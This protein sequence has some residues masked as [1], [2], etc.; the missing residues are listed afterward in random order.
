MLKPHLVLAKRKSYGFFAVERASLKRLL[1]E[2]MIFLFSVFLFIQILVYDPLYALFLL[3]IT[4]L[5]LTFF[6]KKKKLLVFPLNISWGRE[7]E[8]RRVKEHAVKLKIKK[9]EAREGVKILGRHEESQEMMDLAIKFIASKKKTKTGKRKIKGSSLVIDYRIP[10]SRFFP[11]ALSATI[12]R[13][14]VTGSFPRIT[15]QDLREKIFGGKGRLSLII[16]LDTSASMSFSIGEILSSFEAIKREAVRYRD[17]VSL[18]ICKG[19]KAHILQHPTTNF[20][21]IVG[22][23]REVSLSDFTPLAEGLQRGLSLALLENRRG[24][25][26]IIILI[27]D[28]FANVPLVEK[29]VKDYVPLG[30]DPA[31]RSL[32]QVAK[33]ISKK[34]IETVVIN[35][36]HM[37]GDPRVIGPKDM[38]TRIM[39]AIAMITRGTYIGLETDRS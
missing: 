24:Y 26:P 8:D 16:V 2:I 23:L 33:N 3:A 39:M 35:T 12:R 17:R 11:L 18:I 25:T 10:R 22:K 27:S 14:V 1:L 19:F 21:L 6:F 36:R 30:G 15:P 7:V 34:K 20:N 13:S 28:G 31:I 29:S 9:R 5:L 38:G 32:L 4:Y 37:E